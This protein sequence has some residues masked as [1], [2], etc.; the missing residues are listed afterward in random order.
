MTEPYVFRPTGAL[1]NTLIQLTSMQ[2]ECTMLHDTVYD[3][4][5][6]NCMVIRGFE[7]VS[8]EGRTP[9]A[10]IYINPYTVQHVHSKIRTI[11]EPT[12]FMRR[13]IEEARPILEG[14]T[15]G[16]SIRR[17]SYCDDS[18]QFR[19]ERNNERAYYFCDD[20]GLEK[21][22][23]IIRR[24]PG[25]VFVSSDSPSTMRALEKEFGSKVRTLD[26][27]TFVIG[28]PHDCVRAKTPSDYHSIYLRFFI[29]SEC[30]H[31]FLT[32]GTTD[33]VGFSTYA[34]MAAIYG[35]RPFDIVFN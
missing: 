8:H 7:R 29:L 27:D 14:V 3:Y 5:L 30:P 16:L 2:P 4:E 11:I 17:G 13:M 33:L 15:C 19:D 9:E 10:P 28:M 18:T 26:P 22:R 31:L 1:G 35:A 12:A 6:A 20:R 24:S 34:Y 25:P 32:G 23:A 21:F